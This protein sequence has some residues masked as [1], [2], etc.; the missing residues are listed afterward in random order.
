MRLK[1]ITF[2]LLIVSAL[3][4][5]GYISYTGLNNLMI[6]LREA[7]QPDERTVKFEKILD[8]ISE[9]EN[10]VRNYTITQE[11]KYLDR[12][13]QTVK[14]LE[15]HIR[16]LYKEYEDDTVLY[17]YADR[18]YDLLQEK[19]YVQDNLVLLRRKNVRPDVYG[20][21]LTEIS[22]IEN[23]LNQPDT[24]IAIEKRPLIV[25]TATRYS[26][27]LDVEAEAQKRGFFSRIFGT[28]E[29]EED[30]IELPEEPVAME[31]N[32]ILNEVNDTITHIYEKPV[33]IS[34]PIQETM[35]KI[36]RQDRY[37]QKMLTAQELRLTNTDN[38]LSMRVTAVVDSANIYIKK[39]SIQKAGEAATL[40]KQTT[41]YIT[42]VGSITAMLFLIL[43]FIVMK[44]FQVILKTKKELEVAKNNTENLAKVKE[45]FLA[46]MSHEI[47][48]PLNAIIGFSKHIS[49]SNLPTRD[50]KYLNII[51]NSSRH[52]FEIINDILDF[53]KLDS[54]QMKIEKTPFDISRL[55]EETTDSFR[56][57][58]DLK[59]LKLSL[60][61]DNQ[62]IGRQIMGDPYRIRQILNNLISNAIKFTSEGSVTIQVTL[63]K[64]NVMH[65]SVTDTGIGIPSDKIKLIFE[66]FAQADTS[67]TRKYGGTGLGLTIVKKLVG[68]MKGKIVVKSKVDHGTSFIVSIPTS[69]VK[70]KSVNETEPIFEYH[71]LSNITCLIADDDNYN[72]MLLEK[73]LKDYHIKVFSVTS[74]QEA[75]DYIDQIQFE[76]IILDLQ[77]PEMDGYQTALKLRDK[78]FRKP[79]L[80]LSAFVDED[81]LKKCKEAGIDQVIS[82]PFD[83][84]ELIMSIIHKHGNDKKT[85]PEEKDTKMNVDLKKVKQDDRD[86]QEFKDK[87]VQIYL[88]N[89]NEF[90]DITA[91]NTVEKSFEKVQYAA[92]KLIPSSRHMGFDELVILLKKTEE[93]TLRDNNLEEA[94]ALVNRSQQ[95]VKQVK[96]EVQSQL[97]NVT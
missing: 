47:R 87:M 43:I 76:L 24:I 45:E 69:L 51:K 75:L 57:D 88:N 92:H 6:T 61:I 59:G 86:H 11:K 55:L 97:L 21:I 13:S 5:V 7:V 8:Y 68:L 25:D 70:P 29:K 53:S 20:E 85:F 77:M 67:T 9:T 60:N 65:L 37:T 62:L 30:A 42:L 58:V 64:Q 74:G 80:A 33:E 12:Y 14:E 56:S 10:N 83:E 50:K 95:I 1:L 36:E 18:I 32:N 2:Y 35:K 31:N 84:N 93:Y 52:L 40:F 44:D 27:P 46:S 78:E 39:K 82:K 3:A 19:V 17:N 26:P 91:A 54:G 72:L 48:T 22:S 4:L 16:S 79:I 38:Q 71:N 90:L 41:N 94:K 34:K 15:D 28:K 81:V 89:L 96:E 63:D 66:K 49:E 73:C 23:Q